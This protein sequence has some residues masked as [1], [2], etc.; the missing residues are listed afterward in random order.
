MTVKVSKRSGVLSFLL[1]GVL[2]AGASSA[3]DDADLAK[4]A[5]AA[6][7]VSAQ[8]TAHPMRYRLR[9]S[10]PRLTTTKEILETKD[11]AVARLIAM[12]DSPLNPSDEQK[13]QARLD[14]LLSDPAKQHHRRQSELDDTSR[15]LK[16]IRA[17]PAAFLYRYAGSGMG[18]TGK[19]EKFSFIP[20]PDFD[21]HDLETEAL[22]Q[23][24][25]EI[26]VDAGQARVARL[27]GHLQDD[28]DFGWGMLGR[29]DKG[30]WIVIEQ[31]DIG[32]HQW[33]IVHFQMAMSGR[34][35]FKTKHFDTAEDESDFVP[36]PPRLDYAEA[37]QI[38][39]SGPPVSE[40]GRNVP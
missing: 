17:L 13:E 40:P 8:D 19:V 21:P 24:R 14:A 36:V 15:V 7:M 2:T 28:V 29:L 31:A 30:G 5:L 25:G 20:N 35:F 38:L 6:E 23:M 10:S 26:W 4:R 22:T 9:K 33:R 1:L 34:V 32:D 37:I 39:R 11:G 16:V 3:I 12:N 18:P 27:E